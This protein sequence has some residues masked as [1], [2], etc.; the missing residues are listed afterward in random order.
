ML[1]S[2]DL[3]HPGW[4]PHVTLARRVERADA[5]RAVDVLGADDVVLRLTTLRR[6]EPAN[7]SIELL[8]SV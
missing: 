8:L 1:S 5:Q 2:P 6:W 3:P 7:E 4:L